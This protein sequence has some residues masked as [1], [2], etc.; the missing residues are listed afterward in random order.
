MDL[1]IISEQLRSRLAL[2][3]QRLHKVDVDLAQ[4]HSA[5]SEEQA[6]ERENDE[7]LDV[8]GEEAEK[9]IQ[10]IKAALRRIEQGEYGICSS[11]GA[12]IKRQRLEIIPES[13]LCVRCS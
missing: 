11:C 9:S 2:L 8:I 6:Q 13:T 1:D 4:P 10:Q 7:V 3:E 12:D 5:D